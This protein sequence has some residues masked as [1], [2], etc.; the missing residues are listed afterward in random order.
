MQGMPQAHRAV[1]ARVMFTN[2]LI[3]KHFLQVR[4]SVLCE[5]SKYSDDATAINEVRF[6]SSRE[7]DGLI[8]GSQE[9]LRFPSGRQRRNGRL[10]SHC[11]VEGA[12][13]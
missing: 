10:D 2:I 13:Q 6:R 7:I 5:E 9:S 8:P 1:H 12:E 11:F 4:V 3:W